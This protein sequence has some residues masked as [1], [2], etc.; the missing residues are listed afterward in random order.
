[1]TIENYDNEGVESYYKMFDSDSAVVVT[2]SDSVAKYAKRIVKQNNHWL[3][4][5]QYRQTNR[6]GL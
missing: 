1:M 2:H 4:N 3:Y 5:F 6:V